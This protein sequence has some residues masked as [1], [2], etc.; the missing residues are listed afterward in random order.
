[1]RR[2]WRK[3]FGSQWWRQEPRGIFKKDLAKL[4]VQFPLVT[5]WFPPN[6]SEI[7]WDFPRLISAYKHCS[8]SVERLASLEKI[9]F[10]FSLQ[11]ACTC[12]KSVWFKES[13]CSE[14]IVGLMYP[15]LDYYIHNYNFQ[16]NTVL[17]LEEEE[18][19]S[20]LFAFSSISST[21]KCWIAKLRMC[22]SIHKYIYKFVISPLLFQNHVGEQFISCQQ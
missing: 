5:T 1:M 9:R 2:A 15:R 17:Y 6:L 3:C 19:S 13:A 16:P 10:F 20:R 18:K 7:H 12:L 11:L 21:I 4:G 22:I 8:R 14:S